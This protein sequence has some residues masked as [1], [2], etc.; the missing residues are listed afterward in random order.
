MLSK[1]YGLTDMDSGRPDWGT[2]FPRKVGEIVDGDE[3]TEMNLFIVRHSALPGG[4]RPGR[5]RRRRAPSDLARPSRL[6]RE[7]AR[8]WAALRRPRMTFIL[9]EGT[10]LRMTG[11]AHG[12]ARY[13]PPCGTSIR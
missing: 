6:T 9:S 3:P 5:G 8:S 1:E 10:R 13:Q 12:K 2:F 11:G 7:P 4:A